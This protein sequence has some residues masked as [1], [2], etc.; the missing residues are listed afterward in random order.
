[1]ASAA[2]VAEDL[3]KAKKDTKK[4]VGQMSQWRLM[5]RRFMQNKLSVLGL[6][7]LVT[8]YILAAFA[9]FL[10][11]YDYNT[12]DTNNQ[13]QK[14]TPIVFSGGRPAICGV[15][16]TLNEADFT[17][18]YTRDCN[19]TYPVKFFVDGT[20]H[21]LLGI[22]PTTK[23]LFG[24]DSPP[25]AEVPVR[26][27]LLGTDSLGRDMLAR[28]LQGA[29]VSLTVGLVGVG[30]AT[31]L[32]SVLGTASG[33]FG[34]AIDNI[35]QRVIELISSVPQIPLWAALAAAL[36][37]D[38]SV[39]RRYFLITVVLSL[40]AWTGLARQLRGKV[41]GYRAAD[42]TSAARA[43]GSSHKRIILTHMI[44]NSLSHIIVVAALAIPGAILAETA[45]SFLGLGMLPPAVSWGVLLAD[46][47]RVDVIL[48]YPWLMIPGVA[49][50]VA[51]VFYQFLGDGLR[52]AA[53]PYS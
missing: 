20:P 22:F 24:V 35:M 11:P 37:R 34:G 18:T 33:Y 53:D 36:P 13:W 9:S 49:V 44:P 32:G 45:L 27:Y 28:V 50:I 6:I 19:T 26:L 41:I 21:K 30:I 5:L 52:D 15:T 29:R 14:P 51:L 8:M 25:D 10:A 46:A 1:M 42:Y 43:A 38:L 31:I 40:V 48:Q 3:R 23:H 12:L 7:G 2:G 39:V 4:D 16:Q 47:Q 17:W